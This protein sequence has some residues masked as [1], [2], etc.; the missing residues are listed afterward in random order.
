MTAQPIARRQR[1]RERMTYEEGRAM[2]RAA[3]E[4]FEAAREAY[5]DAIHA[6]AHA[7]HK[8]RHR[9]EMVWPAIGECLGGIAAH[10]AQE[11]AGRYADAISRHETL[12][13]YEGAT[14]R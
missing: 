14:K 9:A 12:R 11:L 3:Q 5:N 1:N 4:N 8:A 6:R 7:A 13:V 10:S 2:L